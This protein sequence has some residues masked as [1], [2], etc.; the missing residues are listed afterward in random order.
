MIYDLLESDKKWPSYSR[1]KAIEAADLISRKIKL[2]IPK[3]NHQATLHIFLQSFSNNNYYIIN[4][5]I[6]IFILSLLLKNK[7]KDANKQ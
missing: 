1:L 5:N 2:K 6:S 4:H 3:Q 7:N